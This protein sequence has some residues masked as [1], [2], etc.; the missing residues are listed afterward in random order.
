MELFLASTVIHRRIEVVQDLVCCC[1]MN[2]HSFRI[3]AKHFNKGYAG[4]DNAVICK[5][6]YSQAMCKIT[7]LFLPSKLNYTY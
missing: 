1:H 4:R 3:Y 6:L 7:R 5:I 2:P